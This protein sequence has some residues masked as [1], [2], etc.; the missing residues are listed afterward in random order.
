MNILGQCVQKLTILFLFL[1]IG[2]WFG[3]AVGLLV[4][5]IMMISNSFDI[6]LFFI[7]MPSS[8]LGSSCLGFFGACCCS[9][10]YCCRSCKQPEK[11]KEDSETFTSAFGWALE[12]YKKEIEGFEIWGVI[13]RTLIIA[14]STIMYPETR[15]RTHMVVMVWS[16]FLHARFRPYTDQ[17]SNVCA[18]LFCVCDIL[19]TITAFQ[20]YENS[21]SAVLQIIF[22]VVT[23]MTMVIVGIATTRGIR[24]QAAVSRSGLLG[25]STSDMFAS[26]TPLE[27]KLLFPVL[28]LVWLVV[29]CLQTIDRK[30]GNTS[31]NN[32]TE[33]TP[34]QIKNWETPNQ[35]KVTPI[36]T[37]S[38]PNQ[39]K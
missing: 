19:G 13:S 3:T 1:C 33:L 9:A 32:E 21:P 14:G 39:N 29:K 12:S 28:A 31:S 5:G 22:I 11:E 36:S 26:Y 2:V 27:K 10:Q 25:R 15:F 4:V 30:K 8:I 37:D 16:L 20:T 38:S 7:I 23:F 18:I 35:T 24:T 17:E 34:S 6:V